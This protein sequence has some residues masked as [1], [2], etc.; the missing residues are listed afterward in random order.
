MKNRSGTSLTLMADRAVAVR[1]QAH[2]AELLRVVWS[3]TVPT[4]Q[5]FGPRAQR[6]LGG[7]AGPTSVVVPG[8]DAAYL[9]TPLPKL[10]LKQ[11]GTALRG[12]LVREKGGEPGDWTIDFRTLSDREAIRRAGRQDVGMVFAR[13][14]VV[15][16][17][18]DRARELGARVSHVLPGYLALDAFYRRRRP[19]TV[20]GPWNLVYLGPQLR[21]LCV[22]DP[23]GLLFTRTLPA[24]LSGGAEQQEYVERL[25][26]EI[27]R[28]NFFAQQAERSLRVD[29]IVVCGEPEL[30]AAVIAQLASAVEIAAEPWEP[31]DL[32]AWPEGGADLALLLP[33][34][35]AAMAM[36]RDVPN[37]LPHEQRPA[38]GRELIRFGRI[39]AAAAAAAAVPLVLG[40]SLL[41]GHVQQECLRTLADHESTTYERAQD[42]TAAYLENRA[43]LAR[44]ASLD[45]LTQGRVDFAGLLLDI[46]KR[47]PSSV[48]YQDLAITQAPDASFHLTLSGE[49]QG[50]DGMQ[51]QEVFLAFLDDLAAST[52]LAAIGEPS[53]LEIAGIDAARDAG[54]GSR[55]AFT[56]EYRITEAR[57]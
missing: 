48:V 36:E 33:A 44:Q 17:H 13:T 7:H 41:T 22:G 2:T 49:S 18:L 24:D 47:T 45:R 55:V 20:T 29:R 9:I 14:T 19:A 50:R 23:E 40:G 42:A 26:T 5:R 16:R 3:E 8:D 54:T 15:N 11:Q 25:V 46:A 27:E 35:A 4:Q 32:F 34:I 38:R 30:T 6:D 51:A 10:K 12:V 53:A 31:Q 43:L 57:P 39:A 28:S 37:L 52:R 1:V 21:F 56:L